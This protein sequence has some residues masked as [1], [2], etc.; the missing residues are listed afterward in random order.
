MR[1]F[2]VTW[3]SLL[4]LYN[5]LFLLIGMSLLWWLTGGFFLALAVIVGYPMLYIG[6]PWWL[7]PIL[8]IPAGPATAALAHVTHR[9]ARELRADRSFFFEGFREYWK[10]ALG[11]STILA[12]VTA[13]LIL[14]LLFYVSRPEPFV[15]ALSLLFV[16]LLVYWLSVQIYAFPILA[17]MKEPSV[18][19]AIK[20]A[21]MMAFAN[22]LFSV[23]IVVIAAAL[24]TLSVVLAI[25]VLLLWPA[26][27]LLLGSH[28]LKLVVER[29][30]P[31]S[32]EGSEGEAAK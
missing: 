26:M 4:S 29:A 23:L 19:G 16:L 6:G 14:N 25:L 12:L 27:M 31:P 15:Q 17:G 13:I 20:M 1:A 18:L 9:V 2:L 30:T 8:A 5:D 21:L 22:P 24:T 10:R 7:A 3:R 11:V 32:E 28:S